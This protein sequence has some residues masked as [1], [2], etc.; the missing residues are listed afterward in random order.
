M[1]KN[2]TSCGRPQL[3][4][5]TK[6][7]AVPIGGSAAPQ[8]LQMSS[9]SGPI[10]NCQPQ[11]YCGNR[12]AF[13]LPR[14]LQ[15]LFFFLFIVVPSGPGWLLVPMGARTGSKERKQKRKRKTPELLKKIKRLLRF[16]FQDEVQLKSNKYRGIS[17]LPIPLR[18][19]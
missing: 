7:P 13:R 17:H 2:D 9:P 10:H 16:R 11:L 3:V 5:Q 15:L 14:L 6:R 12:G 18:K 8:P 1:K 19:L 4:R